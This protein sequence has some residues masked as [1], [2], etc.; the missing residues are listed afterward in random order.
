MS[1]VAAP[2]RAAGQDSPQVRAAEKKTGAILPKSGRRFC[3]LVASRET[4]IGRHQQVSQHTMRLSLIGQ[5]RSKIGLKCLK[6]GSIY[7]YRFTI[8]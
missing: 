3:A 6:N 4:G 1:C 5:N 7:L 2:Q 8:A